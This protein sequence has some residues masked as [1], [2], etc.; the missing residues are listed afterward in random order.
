MRADSIGLFW[1][2]KAKE[3]KLPK[4]KIKRLPPPKDWLK[5]DYL[6]FLKEALDFKVSLINDKELVSSAASNDPY[7]FDVECYPNYFLVAFKNLTNKK[8]TYIEAT[9]T[10]PL[11][12]EKLKWC[13]ENLYI[14]SFNGNG[15]D[16]P[17]VS[18][19]CQGRSLGELKHLSDCI[20][21]ENLRSYQFY[22]QM[23]VKELM[24]NHI[25]IMEVAPLSANLKIYGGRCHTRKMQDLPFPPEVTL[26]PNQIAIV[27]LYCINDLDTTED[28]FYELEDDIKLR[29]WLGEDYNVDVRSKSDAQCAEAII[30]SEIERLTKKRVY[31]PRQLDEGTSFSYKQPNF[32]KFESQLMKWVLERVNNSPFEV[33]WKGNLVMSPN[34]E[35]L[36][37][38]IAGTTYKMGMGG[39][40]SQEVSTAHYSDEETL[41]EDSDVTSYYPFIILNQRLFPS[42]LGPV[43]LKVYRYLVETRLNAKR[44]GDK[45][46]A[47]SLKIVINGS[48]G[49]L[50]SSYS[51]LYAPQ[52]LIQVT[53]TGQLSLLMLIERLELAGIPVVSANTDGI[54]AKCPRE[55]LELKYEIMK[56]W[57]R[58]TQFNLEH[59]PYEAF[60]SKD[61][62][63][64]IAVKS[65][66]SVKTK[67]AYSPTGLQKNPTSFACVKAV[68]QFLCTQTPVTESINELT[69]IRDFL[70]VR[71][72]KG[73]AVSSQLIKY[74]ESK[75]DKFNNEI[76]K[77]NNWSLTDRG[78]W[79][80]NEWKELHPERYDEL[81]ITAEQAFAEGIIEYGEFLGKAIRWYYSNEL[82]DVSQIVYAK[83]GN[84]VPKSDGARPLMTLVEAIPH[85][86][87][88]QW[89]I[90]EANKIL[91][92]I[93]AIE[94]ECEEV[95]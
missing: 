64:Y 79:V 77:N 47:Q 20:I 5:P 50:G 31:K 41:L 49:K 85:D 4:A 93:G 25:D 74:D 28:L 17:I 3:K 83:S 6:P 16:L 40:H 38:D 63:N 69:D 84:K 78:L 94:S 18:A 66:T 89:Y 81:A 87:D 55:K 58:E 62:N 12:I 45:R 13:I 11:H 42:H 52:L 82:K 10:S 34:L 59:T 53:L 19:A 21:Q 35:G 86:L 72:V 46:K 43:F 2:D 14:V 44:A 71:A 36:T 9:N 80:R 32:I 57:E 54:V 88:R 92:L 73:G 56:Q 76:L 1:E 65:P 22:K 29:V 48:F 51:I 61:V 7:V 24:S 39:L 26:S 33:D 8:I 70:T 67:G 60:Y 68:E 23:K 75:S 95:G 37:F 30:R 15:Y 90:D 91:G 27:R